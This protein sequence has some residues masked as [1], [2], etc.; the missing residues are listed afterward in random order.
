MNERVLVITDGARKIA[1]KD[2]LSFYAL[3]IKGGKEQLTAEDLT[4]NTV[5]IDVS[6]DPDVISTANSIRRLVPWMPLLLITD[7]GRPMDNGCFSDIAGYGL[8]RV[9]R[10]RTSYIDGMLDEVLALLHPEYPSEKNDVAIVLPVYNEESRFIN[11]YNFVLK[12]RKLIDNTIA[13]C[14]IYF[15]NDGSRDR[16]QELV[17][18]LV[19]EA[20]LDSN[21]VHNRPLVS[22]YSLS[23]NTRKA[24]TLIEALKT[25]DAN[26]IIMADADDSF[27]IED[28]ARMIN[29]L[30]DGYYDM[31]AGTKDMTAENRAFVRRVVSFLKRML[32]K[33]FLPKGIYDSQTGLKALKRTAA[34][35]ILP[36]LHE[37]TGLAIDLEMMYVAKK[38]NFR[39]CQ[40]PVQCTDREGTHVNVI[41]DSLR[42][43]KIMTKLASYHSKIG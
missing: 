4:A 9:L 25:I 36:H 41:K 38:L 6:T 39:V 31:V 11:V 1:Y 27:E 17:Q 24:G 2:I 26:I 32:T 33:P 35:H 23:Y 34:V 28:I 14:T 19:E 16:T 5:I 22:G 3:E 30:Q 8:T 37:E 29:M 42:F 21:L 40:L 18:K 12:L 13:N 20:R 15:I 10:W 43:I 7:F